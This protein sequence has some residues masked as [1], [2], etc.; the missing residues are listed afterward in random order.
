MRIIILGKEGS[1]KTIFKNNILRLF[2]NMFDI[3]IDDFHRKQYKNINLPINGNWLIASQSESAISDI[4]FKSAIV[5]INSSYEFDVH[6]LEKCGQL[7]VGFDI[8][9][10]EKI[11]QGDPYELCMSYLERPV[12][13]FYKENSASM[14]IS[15]LMIVDDTNM[16]SRENNIPVE[17]SASNIVCVGDIARLTFELKRNYNCIYALHFTSRIKSLNIQL[18]GYDN[19]AVGYNIKNFTGRHYEF[20]PPLILPAFY[21]VKVC[22][23]ID[24][25]ICVHRMKPLIPTLVQIDAGYVRYTDRV[26]KLV[27]PSDEFCKKSLLANVNRE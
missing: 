5:F 15:T 17:I 9:R 21:T 24:N 4:M 12:H 7:Y 22:A 20:N 18:I 1:G 8:D 6:T 11:I 2:P 27:L 3:V 16:S 10:F 19:E 26:R 23:E 13:C 25:D 14:G